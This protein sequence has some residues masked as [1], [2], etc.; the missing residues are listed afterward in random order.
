MEKLHFWKD[1]SYG[2]IPLSRLTT[3][4]VAVRTLCLLALFVLIYHVFTSIELRESITSV[5]GKV[6]S[7]S[8][9]FI[10]ST[11]NGKV[12]PSL[13]KE[14]HQPTSTKESKPK[15]K[16]KSKPDQSNSKVTIGKEKATLLMLVRHVLCLPR[17]L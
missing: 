16:P 15:S 10:G 12:T 17:C 1:G 5:G 6:I 14:V 11:N 2:S 8:G 4:R 13:E 9:E 3:K 7:S